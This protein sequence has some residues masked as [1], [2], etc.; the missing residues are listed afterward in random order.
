MAF[1]RLLHGERGV[2]QTEEA[3]PPLLPQRGGEALE[4]LLS[5]LQDG[6]EEGP[7]PCQLLSSGVVERHRLAV[8]GQQGRQDPLSRHP[9]TPRKA[10]PPPSR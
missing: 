8:A 5:P 2:R 7:A 1:F 9:L 4:P 3:V 6:L 10:K